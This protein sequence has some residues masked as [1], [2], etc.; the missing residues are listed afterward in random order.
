MRNVPEGHWYLIAQS[1]AESREDAIHY[2]PGGDAALCI[3]RQGPI[4]IGP[5]GARSAPTS[6][7]SR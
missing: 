5:E 2:P 7:S 4:A 6:G 3:A 1:V